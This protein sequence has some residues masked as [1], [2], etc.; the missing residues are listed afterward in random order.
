MRIIIDDKHYELDSASLLKIMR[1]DVEKYLTPGSVEAEK[2]GAERI[3]AKAA[4]RPFLGKLLQPIA[5]ILGEKDWRVLKPAKGDDLLLHIFHK[6]TEAFIIVL[7]NSVLELESTK[8]HDKD[9]PEN[10]APTFISLARTIFQKSN[11]TEFDTGISARDEWR[12]DARK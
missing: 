6:A 7:D 2:Y 5:N 3:A 10:D 12:I 4:I 8:N 11:N 1:E 9:V